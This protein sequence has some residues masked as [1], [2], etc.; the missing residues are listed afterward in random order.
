MSETDTVS[1]EGV[2]RRMV[3]AAGSAGGGLLLGFGIPG[4]TRAVAQAKADPATLGNFIKIAPD[5]VVTIMSKNPEIGQ[6]I[7]TDRSLPGVRWRR[8]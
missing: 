5:G 1:R 4:A 8:R 7:N 6:G 3:L 2:S